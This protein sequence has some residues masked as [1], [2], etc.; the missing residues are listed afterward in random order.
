MTRESKHPQIFS[1][2]VVLFEIYYR[3]HEGMPK[4]FRVA[5]SEKV[6]DRLS[7]AMHFI[8]LANNVD[9]KTKI[10]REKGVS[11]ILHLKA[12]IE[13]AWS[14]VL[15]GWKLKFVSNGAMAQLSERFENIISQALKWEKWFLYLSYN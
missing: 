15:L 4:S 9:K 2:I 8:I 12:E 10:G 14:F 13:I 1:D 3:I 6:L 5:V 7:S 11:N